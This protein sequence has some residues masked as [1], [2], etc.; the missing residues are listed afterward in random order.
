MLANPIAAEMVST[1]E[2]SSIKA[3]MT[4][5]RLAD[6][7]TLYSGFGFGDMAQVAVAYASLGVGHIRSI[8]QNDA[9]WSVATFDVNAYHPIIGRVIDERYQCNASADGLARFMAAGK[10]IMLW[11][12]SDDTLVSHKDTIRSWNQVAAL[13]GAS[14]TQSNSRLYIASGVHPQYPKYKGSGDVNS[15]DSYA[16]SVG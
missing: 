8:V 7:T 4:D 15:A 14:V 5:L 1:V 6:A 16:C 9:S 10:K 13:A 11:H 2:A 12:G 3:L